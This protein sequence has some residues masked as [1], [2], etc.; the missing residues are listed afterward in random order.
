MAGGPA[1]AC[2]LKAL[3]SGSSPE[4]VRLVR[5]VEVL[6]HIGTAEAR[7]LLELLARG[8]PEARIT[9]EAKAALTRL[10]RCPKMP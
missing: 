7:E 2:T 1:G 5:A 10:Q 3:E 8:T 4:T 9:R 6:E